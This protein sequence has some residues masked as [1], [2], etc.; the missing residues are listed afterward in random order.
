MSALRSS[1]PCTCRALRTLARQTRGTG[2]TRC[3]GCWLARKGS[4]STSR[5]ITPRQQDGCFTSIR[6][7]CCSQ[8]HA[9]MSCPSV[10]GHK[11]TVPRGCPTSR[12]GGE[13]FTGISTTPIRSSSWMTIN[14]SRLRRCP[15]AW[16]RPAEADATFVPRQNETQEKTL[17]RRRQRKYLRASADNTCCIVRIC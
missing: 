3:W 10:Q 16:L 13:S 1:W 4:R 17:Q 9:S 12:P 6:L 2:C 7:G 11:R 14:C 5:R 15:S 8:V